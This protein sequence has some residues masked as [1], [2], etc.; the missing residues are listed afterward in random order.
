MHLHDNIKDNRPIRILV[1][2]DSSAIRR[3]I[4]KLLKPLGADILEAPDGKQ[5]YDLALE[6]PV[7]LVISDVDMPVLD[8]IEMCHKLKS[9]PQTR[10]LPIIL[11]SSFNA[12]R[13][14]DRGF[15]A[16]AAAYVF[17]GESSSRLLKVVRRTLNQ[18]SF[19]RDCTIM[20]VD[21]SR[22]IQRLVKKG[23]SEVGFGIATAANGQE[24]LVQ[25][26]TLKPDLIISDIDMPVMN[27]AEFC[28]AVRSDSRFNDIPFVV[29][30][31]N[32]ER[33]T[34]KR[35]L[36]RGAS[37]FITKPFNIDE[38]VM[39]VERFLSDHYRLLLREKERLDAEQRHLLESITSLISALEARDAYTRGHS[40]AVGRIVSGM[41][42]LTGAG[43]REVD[44]A[45]IGGRLHDIGKIGVPDAVLLKPGKLSDAEF[46]YIKQ[47][48]VIGAKILQ[49][50]QSLADIRD[51]VLSHHERIDGAGY[52][53]GLAG[54][55]IPIAARI[56]A[57]ADCYHA[58]TSDR[59]YRKGVGADKALQ[60]I[61]DVR[62]TQLCPDCVALFHRYLE[63]APLTRV[64]AA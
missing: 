39:L 64:S 27:G 63:A 13:D 37:A 44:R 50:I 52:P 36:Q 41:V 32:S 28:D 4:A 11:H 31:A 47:H 34:M 35:M 48:P 25:L 42:E 5:G 3:G 15:Q 17:K 20:V 53:H 6:S 45:T 24:A 55:S 12:D 62:G 21:D 1:V 7:D 33:A 58:L 30:S 10:A 16:G 2:E 9:S 61:D 8:G 59:P 29:M 57:V 40:E 46:N 22:T 14:I 38:L 19:Q 43:Q 26:A 60:I 54:A 18:A 51:I 56:T 23:L 49:S